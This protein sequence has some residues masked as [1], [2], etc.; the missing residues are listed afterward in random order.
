V[1]GG[2]DELVAS[3]VALAAAAADAPRDLVRTTKSTMRSTAAMDE[4][5]RAVDAELVPQSASIGTPEFQA[6]LAAV[7]AR[8]SGADR[9]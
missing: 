1:D 8:I 5:A 2:H 3:A 9:S 7:K 4:H 6:K